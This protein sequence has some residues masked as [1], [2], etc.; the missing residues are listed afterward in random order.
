MNLKY[1]LTLQTRFRIFKSFRK[2][3]SWFFKENFCLESSKIIL[4]YNLKYPAYSSYSQKLP[5][6]G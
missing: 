6:P 4:Q 1:I 5:V 3:K 2:C